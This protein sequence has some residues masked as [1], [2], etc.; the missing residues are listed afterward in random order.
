MITFLFDLD[1]VIY[2]D[3]EPVVNA[4]AAVADLRARGHRILFA[5]NNATRLRSEFAERIREV[6]VPARTEDV[7]TS[8]SATAQYL[9]ALPVPPRTALVVGS[10]ALATELRDVGIRV[11]DLGL[12]SE[13]RERVDVVV[14]SLDREFTYAKLA[15]AQAA[16]LGGAL[17]VATN[18]DPQWPGAN[19][20]IWPGAGSI[21][22][23]V[24]TACRQT[25]VSIG[26]PG[27]LLYQTLLRAV[28]ADPAETIVVGD[29]LETDIAAA[30]AMGLASALVLT[31]VSRRED[32]GAAG[33]KPTI[34]VGTLADLVA[35]DPLA[36]LAEARR[37]AADT[38]NRPDPPGPR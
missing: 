18:R 12:P 26:K 6:G 35:R 14:A 2:R 37:S 34:V 31:G 29:N 20:T 25:A 4:A 21:V 11:V 8:A 5:T 16:V 28:G 30:Q 9:K 19:G 27:P 15:Q 24:E 23:A 32:I 33:A 22:A 3:R 17:L 36:L 7:A 10:E 1:G 38:A 13:L